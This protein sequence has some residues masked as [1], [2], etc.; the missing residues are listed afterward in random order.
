MSDQNLPV[1]TEPTAHIFEITDPGQL[2]AIGAN[3]GLVDGPIRA[4]AIVLTAVDRDGL[5]SLLVAPPGYALWVRPADEFE[6]LFSE[7]F[8]IQSLPVSIPW[9]ELGEDLHRVSVSPDD[10]REIV[11][12]L[13][14]L[15]ATKS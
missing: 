8:G 5:L 2:A 7:T 11:V 12:P 3:H 9:S 14:R 1:A 6:E 10:G 13:D 15:W 4:A